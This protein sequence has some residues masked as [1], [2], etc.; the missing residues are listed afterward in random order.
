MSRKALSVSFV[1]AVLVMMFLAISTNV[2]SAAEVSKGT[3]T[4]VDLDNGSFVVKVGD[5]ELTLSINED[6]AYSNKGEAAEKGDVLVADKVVKVTH[7]EG[8]AK[9][10]DVQE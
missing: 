9:S 1:A 5:D 4:S 8:V 6:T 2:A 10:V 3:I 7:D